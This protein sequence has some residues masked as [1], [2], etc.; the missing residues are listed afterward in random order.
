MKPSH[1]LTAAALLAASLFAAASAQAQQQPY[2]EQAQP[3]PAQAQPY[4]AQQ[5][6]P[7]QRPYPAQAQ[8]P[9]GERR[10][11]HDVRWVAAHVGTA[12]LT[13]EKFRGY[14]GHREAALNMLRDARR[15]LWG[16]VDWASQHG[17]QVIELGPGQPHRLAGDRPARMYGDKAVFNAQVQ[18]PMWIDMLQRDNRDFGGHR[19]AAIGLLQRAEPELTAALQSGQ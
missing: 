2:P 15:E 7:E 10:R 16:A 8:R 11:M 3:Y 6:Y 12:V 1:L 17:Y 9:Y 13:L 18:V 19:M 4:P 5:P 14:G